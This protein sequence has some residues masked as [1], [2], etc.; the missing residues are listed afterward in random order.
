MT[1]LDHS[2]QPFEQCPMCAQAVSMLGAYVD[3]RARRDLPYTLHR[4]IVYQAQADM[5]R[6][7]VG[8]IRN[9]WK[10]DQEGEESYREAD[11][12]AT[13]EDPHKLGVN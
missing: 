1:A 3:H 13:T 11:A 2:P 8:L 4:H 10:R 6:T 5:A 9:W 7:F 12:L